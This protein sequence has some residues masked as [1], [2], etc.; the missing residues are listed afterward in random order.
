MWCSLGLEPSKPYTGKLHKLANFIGREAS[1]SEVVNTLGNQVAALHSVPT[2]I[3]C[4]LRAQSQIP[5]IVVSTGAGRFY[6]LIADIFTITT[7][8]DSRTIR[9]GAPSSTRSRWAATRT[10]L[11]A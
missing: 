7:P 9:S 5:G 11:Q 1:E 4:F 3:H 2:A 10:Q 6:S 8:T